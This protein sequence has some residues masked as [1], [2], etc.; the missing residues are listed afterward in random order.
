MRVY[1]CVVEEGMGYES[2]EGVAKKGWLLARV[3]MR[4]LAWKGW[5]A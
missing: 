2:V 5:R 4:G 1:V 3:E